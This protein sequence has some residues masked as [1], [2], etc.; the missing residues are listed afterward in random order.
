MHMLTAMP[1]C[2]AFT[3]I[4]AGY[5]TS[6]NAM[7]FTVHCLSANPDKQARLLMEVDAFGQRTPS[8]SDL[9]EGF[10]YLDAVLKESMRLYP[11]ATFAVREAAQD[12]ELAGWL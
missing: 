7:A 8:Y 11:P 10:P 12:Q 2:Q 9:E 3:S 1:C 4:L 6:A 5:E